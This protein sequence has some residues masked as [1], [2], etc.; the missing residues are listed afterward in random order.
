M[1]YFMATVYPA[2]QQA[3]IPEGVEVSIEPDGKVSF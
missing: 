3:A 2:G 1:S